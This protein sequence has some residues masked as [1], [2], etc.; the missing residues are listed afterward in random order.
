M[1]LADKSYRAAKQK[2][3]SK[4]LEEQR[5]GVKLLEELLQQNPTHAE[6]LDLLAQALGSEQEPIRGRA[7]S[8]LQ[9]LAQQGNVRAQE[10]L[11]NPASVAIDRAREAY[12]DGRYGE[13]LKLAEEALD[14]APRNVEAQQLLAKAQA[15]L[16]TEPQASA[17]PAEKKIPRQ[18]L[19]YYRRARSY[20]GAREYHRAAEVLEEAL[21]IA[22]EAGVPFE[23]AE[24]LWLDLQERLAQ[25][26]LRQDALAALESADL[27]TARRKLEGMLASGM[28]GQAEERLLEAIQALDRAYH[29]YQYLP[30]AETLKEIGA[31]LKLA[32][33][34]PELRRAPFYKKME[35]DFQPLAEQLSQE[36]WERA[37][38]AFREAQQASSLES[39]IKLYQESANEAAVVLEM[40]RYE[41]EVYH[42]KNQAEDI[43]ARLKRVQK[44]LEEAKSQGKYPEGIS[45]AILE[46]LEALAPNALETREIAQA[47]RTPQ[48][49]RPS[50]K[51]SDWSIIGAFLIFLGFAFGVV[52]LVMN[53]PIGI[54]PFLFFLFSGFFTMSLDRWL[55]QGD[56]MAVVQT[57][58]LIATFLAAFALLYGYASLWKGSALFVAVGIMSLIGMWVKP[59][60]LRK[61]KSQE[62]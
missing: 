15:R 54:L 39:K 31:A 55:R 29:R 43:V 62:S 45:E 41:E 44:A 50:T 60:L 8:A 7:R 21:K 23:V 19:Q 6:A 14:K 53:I 13:A 34:F 2:L 33:E 52:A 26:Q 32:A 49:M 59:K 30:K 20:L 22:E 10:I 46:E 61:G 17:A 18:A 48:Q 28:A 16:K 37:N 1:K 57:F 56:T 11:R 47:L 38:Q 9:R 27:T 25:E 35:K 58:F 12:Y 42:L 51:I 24:T 36:A 4:F 3:G 5:Q 40:G